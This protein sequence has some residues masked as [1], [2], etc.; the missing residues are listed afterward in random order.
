[1]FIGHSPSQELHV[2]HIVLSARDTSW[3]IRPIRGLMVAC[4]LTAS[5]LHPIDDFLLIHQ[6]PA[7]N[8]HVFFQHVEPTAL[9]KFKPDS[10]ALRGAIVRPVFRENKRYRSEG[11]P[12]FPAIFFTFWRGGVSRSKNG[13]TCEGQPTE[14]PPLLQRSGQD[15]DTPVICVAADFIAQM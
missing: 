15:L 12:V 3:M 4:M 2:Q 10:V 8:Q 11:F 5:R 6:E 7:L 13:S 9:K 14:N 1:M